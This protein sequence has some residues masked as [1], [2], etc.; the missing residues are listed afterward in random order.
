MT[1]NIRISGVIV[2]A[3]ADE[4]YFASWIEKGVITPESHFTRQLQEA[5]E[6]GDDVVVEINSYGGDVMAGNQMLAKFQDF[7]G[8][9]RVVLGSFVAS[10]AANFALQCG[11]TV[12]AHENTIMLFHSARSTVDGGAGAMRDEATMIEQINEP[13][14]ARLLALGVPAETVEEGFAEGRQFTMTAAQLKEYGI[15]SHI[16]KGAAALPPRPADGE[17]ANALKLAAYIEDVPVAEDKPDEDEPEEEPKEEPEDK[18]EDED[19]AE[20]KAEDEPAD[21]PAEAEADPEEEEDRNEENAK[22]VYV[23]QALDYQ[24]AEFQKRLSGLQAAKDKEIAALQNDLATAQ[25]QA[26][27]ALAESKQLRGQLDEAEQ[28]LALTREQLA[29]LQEMHRR[30]AGRALADTPDATLDRR[31]AREQLAKLP[32]SKREAFYQA[33]KDLL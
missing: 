21:E 18:A 24:A 33:H 23:Q 1:R 4:P 12:H 10:M 7:K 19:K 28:A 30:M 26:D 22:A 16:V 17:D 27:E 5:A 2:S 15:V 25:K 29:Q 20:G 11:A 32:M 3:E 13:I 6:A 14:K 9:K 31:T 8:G